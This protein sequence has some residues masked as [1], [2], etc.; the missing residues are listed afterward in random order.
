MRQTQL[1]FVVSWLNEITTLKSTQFDKKNIKLDAPDTRL[2]LNAS[3]LNQNDN[4]IHVVFCRKS[5]YITAPQVRILMYNSE[6]LARYLSISVSSYY[7][8]NIMIMFKITQ[9][10]LFL[11]YGFATFT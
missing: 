11:H 4:R 6:V 1:Y 2:L 10:G 3:V 5:H 9:N 8:Q 7:T